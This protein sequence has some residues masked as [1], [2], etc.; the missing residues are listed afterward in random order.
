MARKTIIV[1]NWKMNHNAATTCAILADLKAKVAGISGIDIGIC[2]TATSL[3]A[4]VET[5]AGSNVAI[6]AQNV[7]WAADGA[8]TGEISTSMLQELGVTYAIVGHSERREYFGETNDGVNKR[9]LAAL[10]AGITP[11]VCVGESKDE[12]VS[13]RTAA[14]VTEQITGSLAGFTGEQLV[15]SV[16]A[17]EPVWAIGTGLTASPEQAQDVHALIR[18]LIRDSHGAAVADAVRIQ[19][20][21]S[22][23]AANVAELMACPDID[24]ALVGG[25][26]LKADD[27][28]AL[29]TN[30]G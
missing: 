8:Y 23:K 16:I 12:R 18:S 26:S 17:Y 9:A 4:A 15:A 5:A 10:A 27:F 19:Y 21:G 20:G 6:G 25:A 11:I 2:P 28:A 7:H 3:V 24:G 1:G 30:A 13:E 14:V 22:V 29:L